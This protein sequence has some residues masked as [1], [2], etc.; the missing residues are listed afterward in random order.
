[1][2]HPKLDGTP[3]FAAPVAAVDMYEEKGFKLSAGRDK[4]KALKD[5]RPE[6]ASFADEVL[7][8]A[9]GFNTTSTPAVTEAIK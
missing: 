1:M 4:D 8:A 6:P 9:Q 7:A 2:H 3:P 5:V